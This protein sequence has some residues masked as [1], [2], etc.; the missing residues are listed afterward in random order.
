MW[1][2]LKN[3]TINLVDLLMFCWIGMFN[4]ECIIWPSILNATLPIDAIWV[5]LL[6]LLGLM[7]DFYYIFVIIFELL[8]LK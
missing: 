1:V 7:G 5:M 6:V 4:A 2:Y 8:V 3:L